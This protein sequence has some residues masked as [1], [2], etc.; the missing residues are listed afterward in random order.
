MNERLKKYLRSLGLSETAS[1]EQAWEFMQSLRGLQANIANALNYNEADTQAR[2]NCDLMIRSL[3]YDPNDPSKL[4]VVEVKDETRELPNDDGSSVDGDLEKAREAARREGVQAEQSRRTA[5]EELAEIAGTPQEVVRQLVSDTAINVD[6]ARQRILEDQRQRTRANIQSDRPQAPAAHINGSMTREIVAAGMMHGRSLNPLTQWAENQDG[7]P[8]LRP[9]NDEIRRATD[10]GWALRSLA[11]A[12][13]IRECAAID[14]IR[15]MPRG[16]H[17]LLQ[18]YFENLNGRAFSTSSLSYVFGTSINAELLAGFMSAEDTTTG[19]WVREADVGNFKTLERTR[20]MKGGTLELLPRGGTASHADYEDVQE[21]YKVHRYARQ[22]VIDEQD[23]V[24]DQ[25]G[26]LSGYVP[27][28]MGDAAGQLRPDLVYSIIL[29][30]AAMRDSIAL[31]HASH[32]NLNTTA[33]LAIGTLSTARKNM[34]LQTENSRNLNIN[35]KFFIVPPAL[36]DTA[37]N[38]A[39]SDLLIDGTATGTQ[40]NRNPNAR[41]GLIVVSEARLENGVT[42][43]TDPTGATTH[44]GSATTWYMAATANNHTIE[45]GYLRGKGRRPLIRTFTLSQ[46]QWGVGWDVEF[47]IGAKALDWRGLCKNTA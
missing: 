28:E 14:G 26:G 45:V 22:F 36:E 30:N 5:I 20:L 44:A 29:A 43:P 31:F 12:D 25:F 2:T 42:D 47:D 19:G 11:L 32:S 17:G 6:T 35:A 40:G 39:N 41:A 24:D 21:T 23:V 1:E 10:R 18:H 34:R 16:S 13:I 9:E 8:V 37:L 38:L 27:M 33:T 7:T 3:G 46:G 15:G 4:L